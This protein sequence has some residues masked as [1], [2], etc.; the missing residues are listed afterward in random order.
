MDL[1]AHASGCSELGLAVDHWLQLRTATGAVIPVQHDGFL[2]GTA[3]HCDLRLS[4][5]DAPRH[6]SQIRLLRSV[7]R[8]EQLHPS[9]ALAVNGRSVQRSVLV[10]DD[11]IDCQGVRLTVELI[12]ARVEAAEVDVET[13]ELIA[14]LS[15]AQLC[16]KI[17]REQRVLE[18]ERG[19]DHDGREG[20]VETA[21]QRTHP[22]SGET[23]S[24]SQQRTDRP[25]RQISGPV[26]T[27]RGSRSLARIGE[28]A[29]RQ[30]SWEQTVPAEARYRSGDGVI[31]ELVNQLRGEFRD[32]LAHDQPDLT[33]DD[34]AHDAE[35]EQL[36]RQI[37]RLLRGLLSS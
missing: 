12:P 1:H 5:E 32:E 9:A 22:E 35:Q 10:A 31:S 8:I 13:Q 17:A 28:P 23:P 37:E 4:V 24:G 27:R 2:I 18:R 7:A 3:P 34:L 21:R 11:V 25:H 26:E 33:V 29:V 15:A 19:L 36:R 30:T 20:R 16:R 14:E 6:H